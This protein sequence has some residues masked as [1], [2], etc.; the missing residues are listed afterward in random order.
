MWDHHWNIQ[1]LPE[2]KG[3]E[4]VPRSDPRWPPAFGAQ[5]IPHNWSWHFSPGGWCESKDF[6]LA[7]SDHLLPGYLPNF[8]LLYDHYDHMRRGKSFMNLSDSSKILPNAHSSLTYDHSMPFGL[9]PAPGVSGISIS[10]RTVL[11]RQVRT[12]V[13]LVSCWLNVYCF[14]NLGLISLQFS[15][16]IAKCSSIEWHRGL[17]LAVSVRLPFPVG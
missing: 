13:S 4:I 2:V 3:L 15:Q 10:A 1:E 9:D 7:F 12:V 17:P 14:R 8:G 16:T 11:P 5:N 6:I